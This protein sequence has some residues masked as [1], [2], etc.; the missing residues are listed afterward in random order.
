MADYACGDF[1]AAIEKF[2]AV[3]RETP[4]HFDA[5]QG[6]SMAWYRKGDFAKAIKH[7]H[8]AEKLRPNEQLVHTNLSLFHMKNGDKEKAEHHGLQARIASWRGNMDAPAPDSKVDADDELRMAPDKP[9]AAPAAPP[10]PPPDKFPDMPW[11]KNKPLGGG[12]S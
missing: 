5:I 3:L 8:A 6:L 10:P 7:G 4:D 11:K 9:P 1:D 2:S 12:Q